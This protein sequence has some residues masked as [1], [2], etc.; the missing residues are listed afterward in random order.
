MGDTLTHLLTRAGVG[1]LFDEKLRLP[2]SVVV[3][4]L[5]RIGFSVR[6]EPGLS[7]M[8]RLVATRS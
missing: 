8:I 7:G 5:E 3:T 6:S 2:P 1:T 4:T